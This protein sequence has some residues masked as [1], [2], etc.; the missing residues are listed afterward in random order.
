MAQP[1]REPIGKRRYLTGPK[2][3]DTFLYVIS[4][5]YNEVHPMTLEV[6]SITKS[7]GPKEVLRQVSFTARSGAAL[8]L[9]GRNGAGKT[10][11]IRIIM[12]VF[13]AD[14]GDVLFDGKHIR[15]SNVRIGYL[16]EERGLYPKVPIGRQ[17]SY[18]ARLRGLSRQ[19]AAAS[20]HHWLDRLGM[21]DVLD[22][23]LETLSKGNQQ[24]IQLALALIADPQIIIL[25]EPFS[26]LDPV[27]AQLLKDIVNE[28][29]EKE[30]IVLF[31]SHQ[32]GYVETFCDEVAILNGG[33]IILSGAIRT[34]RRT[35]PRTRL[36]VRIAGDPGTAEVLGALAEQPGLRGRILR[37]EPDEADGCVV[38]LD[39]PESK[40]PLLSG[41]LASGA[42]VETFL[43]IEPTLEEIFVEKV[44]NAV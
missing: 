42:S 41:L 13:P 25:D 21:Q 2:A 17:L 4:D 8:G 23:K 33:S 11:A 5:S 29:V 22:K 44:G 20:V 6:R 26:G 40:D 43:V 28:Q 14:A 27:N 38:H 34:I 15:Q 19:E 10:T 31:S 3:N 30:K 37:V 18:L 35:Y 16:P 7:F 12:D 32:M 9:L 36:S 1:R 24:K 39:A